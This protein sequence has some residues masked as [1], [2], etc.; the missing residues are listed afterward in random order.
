[1]LVYYVLGH[2]GFISS[3]VY[4]KPWNDNKL[5]NDNRNLRPRNPSRH[6]LQAPHYR[7][8]TVDDRTPA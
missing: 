4:P 7:A 1:M 5:R 6:P 8:D 2:A 3:T